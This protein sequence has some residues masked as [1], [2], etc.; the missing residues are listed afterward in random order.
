MGKAYESIDGR[1]REFTESEPV[2]FTAT[3]PLAADGA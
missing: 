2:F 3:V 1:V